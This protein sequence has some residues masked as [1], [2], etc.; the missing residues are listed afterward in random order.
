MSGEAVLQ[1]I[2][3]DPRDLTPYKGNARTHSPEQ[4]A[5][6]AA[7]IREFGFASPILLK[8]DE[9]QIGA[10]HARREAALLLGLTSVPTITL[11]GLSES[12]WR[13]FVLADNKLALN[14]GWDE[15]VLR[16]EIEALGAEDIDLG[17]L[18]FDDDELDALLNP[19]STSTADPDDV[20]DAPEAPV[21]A[22]G[23]VWLLGGHRIMCGD[24]TDAETV[25]RALAG[26]EPHLMVTDPPYGVNYDANWRVAAGVR[27]NLAG[28]TAVGKVEND[29]RADW[30][31]AWALFPG[32]VS[33]VWHAGVHSPTV[34][35]SLEANGLR[36]RALII[37]VKSNYPMGRGDYH[38][39]HEPCW[40]MV[41]KGAT[42]HWTGGRKQTTVWEIDSPQKSET[43][44][45][46]QKPIE[47]MKRP[48]ENNSKPGEA[49]YEPFSGSGT[50]IIAAEMTGRRCLAI[51][52]SPAYV[53]VA[54]L[55]WENFTGRTATLEATGQT[56]QEVQDE[57]RRQAA[58]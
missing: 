17:L 31:E 1:V 46:T 34:A 20:P 33:Y 5:Q 11:H 13:A 41:R 24:S 35:A 29:S 58:A 21:S 47:C 27:G 23:D 57:R 32:A 55:R 4:I 12:K 6:I 2:Y 43:G 28:G 39:K 37:W 45:S 38:H 42:G 51:E 10:G 50:T 8:D 18:G 3:R 53:D 44:H 14:A 25:S 30:S 54:V 56:F 36:P 16:A 26:A 52:L 7:S 9:T 15:D 19:P 40:Y 49:V 22:L 48:I